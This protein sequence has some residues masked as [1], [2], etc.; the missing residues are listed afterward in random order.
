VLENLCM[1]HGFAPPA[2]QII[3]TPA[4]NA[5][6]SGLRDGRYVVTVTRGLLDQLADA[7]LKGV[8]MSS[9]ISATATPS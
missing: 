2:L 6:A 3:E 9:H 5:Y 7:A 1:S 4:L 8:R